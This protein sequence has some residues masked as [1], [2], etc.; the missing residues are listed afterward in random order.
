MEAGPKASGDRAKGTPEYYLPSAPCRVLSGAGAGW[1][2]TKHFHEL[3]DD[4]DSSVVLASL[5][6]NGS[7]LTPVH[8]SP[9]QDRTPHPRYSALRMFR[10]V[11]PSSAAAPIASTSQQR[12]PATTNA[13]RDMYDDG[14][15]DYDASATVHGAVTGPGEVI[16]DAQRWMRSV[17]PS[18]SL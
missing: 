16:A 1:T 7:S 10:F 12:L 9:Y 15:D 13:H 14:D 8:A 4:F 5:P 2:T 18:L 3:A 6:Y 17:P 11:T